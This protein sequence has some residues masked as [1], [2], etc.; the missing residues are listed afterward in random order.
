MVKVTELHFIPPHKKQRGGALQAPLAEALQISSDYIKEWTE[1]IPVQPTLL[2][3]DLIR[4]SS[5]VERGKKTTPRKTGLESIPFAGRRSRGKSSSCRIENERGDSQKAVSSPSPS[6]LS[7]SH[8][9]LVTS[10]RGYS[11][12]AVTRSSNIFRLSSV[13]KKS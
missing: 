2:S 4:D 3:M 10:H 6:K 5:C 13:N 12:S 7:T 9:N 1:H 8:K 11:K